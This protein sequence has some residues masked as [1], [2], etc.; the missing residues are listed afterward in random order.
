MAQPPMAQPPMMQQPMTQQPV[1]FSSGLVW[2]ILVLIFCCN[3]IAIASIVLSAIAGNEFQKGDFANAMQ[4]AKLS[5]IITLIAFILTIL[6]AVGVSLMPTETT[7]EP[8]PSSV[9]IEIE[10]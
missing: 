4:H 5:K 8:D 3:P 1:A 7:T 10:Q 2:A 9:E 6:F